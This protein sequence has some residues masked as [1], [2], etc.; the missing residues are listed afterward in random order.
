MTEREHTPLS[1]MTR[2]T[3]R[4]MAI[5]SDV[6]DHQTLTT[7]QIA[8]VHFPDADARRARRRLLVLFRYGVLDRFRRHTTWG[9]LPDHWILAATGAELLAHHREV[10]TD[11]LGFHQDQAVRLAYSMRL[12][13]VQG[14][15]ESFVRFVEAG[16][17]AGNL[18]RWYG[19]RECA[20]RWGVHIRPDAY[21]RW[22][23]GESVLH[24][25]FEYDT[26]TES[27]STVRRKMIGY[28]NLARHSE[29]QSIVLFSVR[30][31]QRE[32]NL[33]AKL[34]GDVSDRVVVYLAT[35][36]RLAERGPDQAVWRPVDPSGPQDPLRLVDIARR[37][38]VS[39]QGEE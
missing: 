12:G 19:E 32:D 10:Q 34:A 4:D 24:A 29:L 2:L 36:A 25:F 21:V 26:G 1:L 8:R 39:G 33:A 3:A 14:L 15:A 35:H 5:V 23:E 18:V 37:H 22:S 16:R 7:H 6:H 11:D 31:N 27:L 13:H 28:A 30:S 9:K 38:P 20:R 17:S